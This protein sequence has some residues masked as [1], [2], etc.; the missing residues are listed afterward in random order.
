MCICTVF[1]A[2]VPICVLYEHSLNFSNYTVSCSDNEVK[3]DKNKTIVS[4]T[5]Y[6]GAMLQEIINLT[7]YYFKIMTTIRIVFTYKLVKFYLEYRRKGSIAK[8]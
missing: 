5:K 6:V 2:I 8:I 3:F 7:N 4:Y 1:S